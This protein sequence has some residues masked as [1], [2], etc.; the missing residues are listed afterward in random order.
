MSSNLWVKNGV[1]DPTRR[2]AFTNITSEEFTFKWGDSPIKVKAGETLE[3][4]HHLAVLATTRLVD[5][6]MNKEI[7]EEEVK[8]RAETRNP[9]YRSPRGLSPGIPAARE[10]YETKI[11]RELKPDETKISESQL[12]VIRSEL[13]ETLVKDMKAE[14]A[15]SISKLT[16]ANKEFEDINLPVGNK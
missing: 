6:I 5:N 10:P 15:P 2:F 13:K 12:G 9:H 14:P 4:P 7:N 11:L 8:M 3:L 1:Y 16:V